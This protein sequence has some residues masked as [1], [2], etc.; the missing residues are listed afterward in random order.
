MAFDPNKIDRIVQLARAYGATRVILFGSALDAPQTAR[1]IDIACD[2]VPGWKL[3]ELAAKI[4]DELEIP[5]DIIP[6]TPASRFTQSI[7][8]R[9]KILL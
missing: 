1:D 2:G 4:E 5:S 3:F 6:L 9:G 8:K 7:E